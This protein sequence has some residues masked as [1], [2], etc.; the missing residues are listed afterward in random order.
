MSIIKDTFFGGAEKKA[1][2]A[3]ERGLD[4][5]IEEFAKGT[6]Q[7][8]EDVMSLYPSAEN[9]LQAGAQ[10]ALDVM[11]Q[12]LPQQADVFQ[13]GNMNAQSQIAG[14]LPQIQNALMGGAIDYSQ[15][16]PKQ[17]NYDPSVFSQQLPEMQTTEQALAPEAQIYGPQPAGQ[18]NPNN[19]L[20]GRFG[21]GGSFNNG[22]FNMQNT[23]MR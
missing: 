16:Q 12:F 8:R 7:A 17:V 22:G 18:F 21:A 5:S 20:G 10:G 15:F 6:K 14:G 23:R 13:Q 11:G 2:E 3:Q 19:F 9:N 4:R 1:A